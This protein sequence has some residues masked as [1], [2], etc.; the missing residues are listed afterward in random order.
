MRFAEKQKAV[1]RD[2]HQRWNILYGATRS[3]KT[4]VS[5][6]LVPIRIQEHYG[7]NALFAGKTLNTL[8]R[9]VF[10]PMRQKFGC[11]AVS[12]IIDKKEIVMFGKRCY[13]VGAND[14]RAI[15]KIQGLGLG[16]AYCDEL[17]T[18]PENFFEMLKSR[19]DLPNSK[20]DATCN[21]ESPSHFVKTHIDNK[22]LDIYAKHFTIYDNP[23]LAQSFVENLEKEYRGTIYF[24]RWILGKWVKTE[25]LV[26][27]LFKREQHYLTPAQ[28]TAAYGSHRIR[29]VIWGGDGATTNDATTL[30]PLAVLD[31]GQSATL[32][33]FYHD[34]KTN[35]PL[36]NEQLVPYIQKYLDDMEEKYRFDRNCVQ[37]F[38]P[39]D[40]AAADLVI[41]LFNRLDQKYSVQKFT[42]KDIRQTT[43]VV[44][45]AL[46]RNAACILNHGGYMNYIKGEWVECSGSRVIPLVTELESMMWEP[47]NEKY[48]PSI[49]NDCADAWRYAINTYYNNPD[50]L[51][52]TPDRASFFNRSEYGR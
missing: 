17:T 35:G 3:G 23:F 38:M 29:Y 46:G 32:E 45:N 31:N 34:P 5:E 52:E 13:C 7:H 51:W 19:L 33:I 48:D 28:F 18:F 11:D 47:G 16:Y 14:D 21:P 39:I 2:A 27:P 12:K 4:E 9:N 25:G 6:Y 8:D 24:D 10:D 50:N 26:Y 1:L 43:D 37:H 40:C 49:P 30:T 41:S 15:T 36:S 42:K 22:D 20:C 44:N